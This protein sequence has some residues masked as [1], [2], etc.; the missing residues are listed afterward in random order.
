MSCV[1]MVECTGGRA[2]DLSYSSICVLGETFALSGEFMSNFVIVLSAHLQ[3]LHVCP[4]Q[5]SIKSESAQI[6][7]GRWLLDFL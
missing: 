7:N 3:L 6:Q 2:P 5:K 4:S 1:E